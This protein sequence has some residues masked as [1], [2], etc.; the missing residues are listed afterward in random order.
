MLPGLIAQIK[1]IPTTKRYN[2]AAVFTDHYSKL[3]YVHLQQALTSEETVQAKHA[4][5]N[6]A[7]THNIKIIHYHADNGRF[8]DKAFHQDLKNNNQTIT[9]SG[10]NAHWQ[11]GVAENRIGDLTENAWAMLL[12][13]QRRWPDAITANLW[14]YAL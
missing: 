1:G 12:F 11:N 2:Y 4:F 9:F 6:Y 10:V 3:G 5:E 13:A 14:P 8:A 7:A